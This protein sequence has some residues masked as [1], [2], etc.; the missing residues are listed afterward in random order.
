[1]TE[2]LQKQLKFL[3]IADGMKQIFRQTTLIDGS[4]PENDAEHSWHFALTAMTLFEHCGI[5]GVCIDRVIRMAV[6]HDLVE[7]Y[8]GDTPAGDIAANVGKDEREREAADKLF[9][10]LPKEQACEYRG[11]WEEFEAMN[12]PDAVYASAVDRFQSFYLLHMSGTGSAWVRFNATTEHVR[13]R[14]LLVKTA[15]PPLWQWIEDAIDANVQKGFLR[16]N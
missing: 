12:T 10:L 1:M 9:A 2:K 7:I 6:L 4:R 8:A 15:I 5:E 11:L 16:K 3:E 14:M 13:A